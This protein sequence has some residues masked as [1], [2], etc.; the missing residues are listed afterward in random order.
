MFEIRVRVN[1]H[2]LRILKA[3]KSATIVFVERD[4]EQE[5]MLLSLL[6]LRK[7]A[8]EKMSQGASLEV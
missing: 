3:S 7:C 5:L 1:L 2:V 8:N 4:R 6:R